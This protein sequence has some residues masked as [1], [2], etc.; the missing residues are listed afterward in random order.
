MKVLSAALA[1]IATSAALLLVGPSPAG[2]TS[3][4]FGAFCAPYAPGGETFAAPIACGEAAVAGQFGGASY[5]A[6]GQFLASGAGSGTAT[7]A[8]SARPSTSQA[9]VTASPGLLRAYAW[10][11]SGGNPGTDSSAGALAHAVVQDG[12]IIQSA[13]LPAGTPVL[14][15]FTVDVS[16]IF[17]GDGEGRTQFVM[18][19]T[20]GAAIDD[21][22][23]LFAGSGTV[24]E[25]FDVTLLVGDELSLIFQLDAYA[26]ADPARVLSEA[27]LSNT[28]ALF[29]DLLTPGASFASLSGHDYSIFATIDEPASAAMLATALLGLAIVMHGRS[30]RL[31]FLRCHR[32]A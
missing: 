6:H 13:L 20:S 23:I 3:I 18:S 17:S 8:G 22:S 4:D 11:T 1:V 29:F 31:A 25:I 30:V 9:G 12:G 5:D 15:R 27:L 32:R 14:G 7:A 2:A 28:A 26:S 16:G 10:S 19:A 21:S 24:L